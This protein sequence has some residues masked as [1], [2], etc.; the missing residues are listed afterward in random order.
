MLIDIKDKG[1]IAHFICELELMKLELLEMFEN[2]DNG[3]DKELRYP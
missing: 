3:G 2:Y 1:E